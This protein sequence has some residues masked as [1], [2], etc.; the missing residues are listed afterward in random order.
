MPGGVINTKM[1]FTAD[2][3]L[4][5][6]K[7]D[8]ELMENSKPTDY[9]FDGKQLKITFP[10]GQVR[11]MT[12]TFPNAETMVIAQKHESQRTFKRIADFSKKLEPLS[13][14]LV[15]DNSSSSVTTT[16]DVSD[17]SKS[18]I[19]ERLQGIW[20]II[21][22]ENVPRDQAPP[23][24]FFNDLWTIKKETVSTSR[25]APPANDSVA[26]SFV[27]GKLASSG[28]SLG[29][30]VGSKLIW[31]T[32]FNE[33]G[34]LVLDSTYCRLIL[35]LVSKDTANVPTVPLKIVLLSVKP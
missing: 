31:N 18:P 15:T 5:S 20:E 8:A 6:L 32:S 28:I 22:Y 7:P 26:F 9:T 2:G 11:V 14:Q 25:R 19:I 10:S 30:P 34:N 16:Y 17:Y 13:L 23:Y 35:K 12:A 21:A 33:W 29:G 24:G 3:K 27:D 1:Y 4:Y